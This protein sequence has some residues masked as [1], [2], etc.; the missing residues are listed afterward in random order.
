MT[1]Q[2]G[3]KERQRNQALSISATFQR[4]CFLLKMKAE[5][6][7]RPMR[8]KITLHQIWAYLM[9]KKRWVHLGKDLLKV[10]KSVTV[11]MFQKTR[12]TK[13]NEFLNPPELPDMIDLHAEYD[14]L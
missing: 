2:R 7:G 5:R 1:R 13:M 3:H 8:E 9:Q 11:D 4:F 10:G 12:G 14:S 6:Q